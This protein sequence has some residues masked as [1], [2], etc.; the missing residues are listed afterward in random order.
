MTQDSKDIAPLLKRARRGDRK[1][2]DD[3]F[4]RYRNRLLRMIRMRLDRRLQARIDSSDIVQEALLDAAR[5]LEEYLGDPR[6]P[7][8][9]W[10]RVLTGHKLLELHR[11]HLGLQCRDA[12]REVKLYHGPFPATST[13]ALADQLLGQGTSP[14]Q[15]ALRAERKVQLQEALNAMAP[16]DREVL[17]LRHFEHLT[18]TEAAHEMNLDP[19]AASKRY[20][21]AMKRLRDIL[22]EVQGT[23]SRGRLG[24]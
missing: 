9:L 12:R 16:L 7:F 19:S 15:R 6:I 13:E 17:V 10:L 2:I 1:A 21:R 18:N 4:S 24:T 23:K 11:H 20:V 14:S 5:R 22:R 8:F 3:L